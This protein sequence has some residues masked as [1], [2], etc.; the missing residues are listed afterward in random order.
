[1]SGRDGESE[2]GEREMRGPRARIGNRGDVVC[3]EFNHGSP[4][5][6]DLGLERVRGDYAEEV[7]V[8]LLVAELCVRGRDATWTC[9]T[10]VP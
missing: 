2:A 4:K 6:T 10:A 5:Q 7:A 3:A 9:K 8:G 1:M